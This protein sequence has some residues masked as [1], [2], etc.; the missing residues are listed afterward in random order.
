LHS[1]GLFRDQIGFQQIMDNAVG[2]TAR[3]SKFSAKMMRTTR[4]RGAKLVLKGRSDEQVRLGPGDFELGSIRE[5]EELLQLG[6]PFSCQWT[7]TV[8]IGT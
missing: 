1:Y 2:Q 5:L 7:K 6:F 3:I 4:E 8:G